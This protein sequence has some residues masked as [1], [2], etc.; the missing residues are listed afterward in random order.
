MLTRIDIIPL[1]CCMCALQ[2]VAII[3]LSFFV[4]CGIYRCM[5]RPSDN[6]GVSPLFMPSRRFLFVFAIYVLVSFCLP[7]IINSI[8][9]L[10]SFF[11]N[12][13]LFDR[14]VIV[15]CM[16]LLLIL[17]AIIYCYNKF[18]IVERYVM[19]YRSW[20]QTIV[21]SMY[22]FGVYGGILLLTS[23]LW[24]ATIWFLR[25]HGINI[26]LYSQDAIILLLGVSKIY[27]V[28]LFIV[29]AVFLAPIVEEIVF[30]YWIYRYFKG[31]VNVM[32]ASVVTGIVFASMHNNFVAFVPLFVLS[33]CLCRAYERYG[34]IRSPMIIH[35]LFNAMNIFFILA[36]GGYGQCV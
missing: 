10:F 7:V 36:G 1:S 8:C 31:K 24:F 4:I 33:I 16:V 11:K 14:T 20:Y 23:I 6:I 26:P 17:S 32:L 3:L 22:S 21:W 30:R 25:G 9:C 2:F 13:S 18:G 12:Q 35:G 29:I 27:H 28:I 5:N 34:D 19:S 15:Q